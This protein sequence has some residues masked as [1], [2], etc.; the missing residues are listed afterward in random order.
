MNCPACGI[1]GSSVL[2]SI[3]NGPDVQR[4]RACQCGARWTTDEMYRKGTLATI[5][6]QERP[7]KASV[8]PPLASNQPPVA[9]NG[10]GGVGGG[11]SSG[12]DSGPDPIPTSVPSR[13]SGARARVKA[14]PTYTPE[15]LAF[16]A[17]YPKKKHKGTAWAAWV[18]NAPP[19]AD[20]TRAVAW[21]RETFD[22]R[23]ESGQFIPLPASYLNARGWEDEPPTRARPPAS[24]PPREAPG[25]SD[26]RRWATD[27]RPERSS[28]D[29]TLTP[30]DWMSLDEKLA[31]AKGTG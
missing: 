21:Q 2:K 29:D 30:P 8:G 13:Q 16:W 18:K 10:R 26:L 3:D 31:A 4:R 28:D 24:P 20:V 12:L 15:F 22:W 14:P 6:G 9:P 1:D 27:L 7:L 25:A 17:A 23:K 11:V 5:S 19:I